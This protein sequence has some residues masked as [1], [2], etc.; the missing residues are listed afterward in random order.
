MSADRAFI[1]TNVFAYLY[2]DSEPDKQKRAEQEISGYER[3]ISTQ[4]LNEF[5]NVGIRKLKLPLPII[6]ESLDQICDACNVIY[7]DEDTVTRALDIHERY[8]Y[9]YY[10]SL[11]VASALEGG[12]R[13]LFSEDMSDGQVIEGILTVRNI[14]PK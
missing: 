10:D 3:F 8:N 4:V 1:D 6:R 14:F 9:S 5:C 11:M 12:C 2:S 7:I 13:Y